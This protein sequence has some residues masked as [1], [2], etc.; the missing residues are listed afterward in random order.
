MGSLDFTVVLEPFAIEASSCDAIAASLL[1]ISAP[2]IDFVSDE[3]SRRLARSVNEEQAAIVQ[4]H[5]TRFGALAILPLPDIEAALVELD[6]AVGPLA[7]DG[8]VLFSNIH[9]IYLGD[10][11][12]AALFDELECRRVTVFVHPTPPPGFDPKKKYPVVF[13]IHGGPQGQWGDEWSYRWNAELM[14][15]ATLPEGLP[16]ALADAYL[17]LKAAGTTNSSAPRSDSAR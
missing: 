11:R 15:A 4:R 1:S 5:P 12:F 17:R 8:V 14:A 9:G 13:L 3:A 6:H 10:P 16:P 7:L 2:G